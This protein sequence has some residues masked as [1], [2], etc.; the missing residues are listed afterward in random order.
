MSG[1]GSATNGLGRGRGT[2]VVLV[3]AGGLVWLFRHVIAREVR[4]AIYVLLMST[5]VTLVDMTMNRN[6]NE[7]FFTDVKVPAHQIV[8][9]RGDGW[10]VANVILKNER[11][12]LADPNQAQA[13]LNL[14]INL[15]RTETVDGERLIDN[16]QFLDRL[17]DGVGSCRLGLTLDTANFYWW[18]HPVSELYPIYEKFAPRVVH[19]HC[20]SIGYPDDKKNVR[21]EMGWEYGKYCCPVYEGDIDFKKL[22]A[23]LRKSGEDGHVRFERRE[24]FHRPRH[25]VVG[26]VGLGG[27]VGHVLAV[28]HI[29]KR[30]AIRGQFRASIGHKYG[31]QHGVKQWQR[32]RGPQPSQ[33]RSTRNSTT[34]GKSSVRRF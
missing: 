14:L 9:R 16:P 8:G 1:T 31:R 12:S 13:R 22:A 29:Q 27:P 33:Y 19:T 5:G 11:D 7:V 28:G 15:L 25:F 17:F 2:T 30:H 24:R 3:G 21:R 10:T 23:I 6:F 18:G 26:T 4:I 20:K 32:Q 34:H